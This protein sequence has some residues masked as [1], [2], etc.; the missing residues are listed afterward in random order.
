MRSAGPKVALAIAA[1]LIG[2]A[3]ADLPDRQRLAVVLFDVE[4]FS[5]AEIAELL[6]VPVGTARSDLFL[7]RRALRERLGLREEK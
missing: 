4:G 3:L 5:H 6:G 2:A 1:L 7:G